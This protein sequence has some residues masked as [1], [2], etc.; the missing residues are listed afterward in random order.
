[1]FWRLCHT[2]RDG[3]VKRSAY[4]QRIRCDKRLQKWFSGRLERSRSNGGLF[5]CFPARCVWDGWEIMKRRE[6]GGRLSS[7]FAGRRANPAVRFLAHRKHI[8]LAR[9]RTS[10][11]ALPG[12]MGLLE[13]RSFA[14]HGCVATPHSRIR[15]QWVWP[16]GGCRRRQGVVAR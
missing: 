15:G 3:F 11:S 6:A 14:A 10:K 4:L 5:P 2:K 7:F 16:G 8:L 12:C 13:T 9:R 1:M